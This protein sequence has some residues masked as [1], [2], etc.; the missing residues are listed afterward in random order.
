MS[1]WNKNHKIGPITDNGVKKA[2]NEPKDVETINIERE[3]VYCDVEEDNESKIIYEP[4]KFEKFLN[5]LLC[6]GDLAKR[7]LDVKPVTLAGLFKFGNTTDILILLLGI[8]FATLSGIAQPVLTLLA[9]RVTNAMIVY[10]PTSTEFFESAIENVYLFGG[11]GIVVLIINFLQYLCFQVCCI[12]IVSKIRHKYILSILRQNTGW[13]DKNH[14]GTLTTKLNDNINRIRDGIGDKLG[15]LL[16]GIVMFTSGLVISYIYEWRLALFM[17]GTAP[18]CCICMSLMSRTISKYTSKELG[19]IGKAGSIAEECLMGVRTVQSLNG[20]EEMTEKYTNE[21]SHGRKYAILKGVSGGFFG[22]LFFLL[23]FSYLGGGFYYGAYLMEIKTIET[24]GDVFTVVFSMLL[25]AYFLGLISPHLM[26]LLNA[27]VAAATIYEI[28]EREPKIDAYS[29]EGKKPIHINGRVT[30]NNVHFR[31]PLRKNVKVLNGLNLVVE[32]GTSVAL[33]GHSGC[34]K[35]TSVGLLTRLYECEQ[36]SVE[37]DGIDVKDLNIDWLR[38]NVG[39]VQQEPI[40]FNDTIHNNLLVG[41]LQATRQKMI[42][43]CKMA[44]AHDFIIKMPKGYDTL[45]GDGGVQLSGGQ[46]QRVAI[47]RTLIRDP[48]I[49]LLDEATSALDAESESIVQSALNNAAAGRTTIMIAHRLSTI[50]EA[51]KIVYFENGVVVESGTHEELVELGGR[52]YNLVQ[53]QQFKSSESDDEVFEDDENITPTVRSRTV[54]RQLSI[55]SYESF[56]IESLVNTLSPYHNIMDQR[57]QEDEDFAAEVTRVMDEDGAITAGYMDI[58]KNAEGNYWYLC[59]GFITALFRGCELPLLSVIMGVVFD[60]F[61]KTGDERS[62]IILLCFIFYIVVGLIT[63]L[64]Q[65]ASTILFTIVA[66]NLGLRFRVKSFRNLLHQ[67]ASFFDNPAHSPGKLITRLASDAPNVKAVVDSRMLQVIYSITAIIVNIIVGFFLCWQIALLENL[68]QIKK[69]E[70]GKI[71][72]EIIENVKTIQLLTATKT[73]YK[74]YEQASDSQKKIDIRKAIIEAVNNAVSQSFMYF[75][76]CMAYGLGTPLIHNQFV[77]AASAFSAINTMLLSSVAVMHSSHNFPEFVK[78]KTAAGMLFKMI[79]RQSKTGDLMQG[80]TPEIRGN[81]LFENVKFSYPQRPLQPVMTNLHFSAQRGQT[82]AIVGP[83][84]SG[85]STCI[86]MLERFYDT[87]AG[88]I[89]IDGND[90]R[91]LSLHHIRTQMALVGQE[92]RLF[93]G[94]IKENICLGLKDVPLERINEALKLSN[95]S[96]FM[97]SLPAGIDTEVGEKG[98]QL[99]GGQKQR[100]AIARALVR[101]PKILLL[102]EAT[103]ALDSQSEK[104]VQ[105]ALDRARTGR[106][107]ITIA[108]R[109]SSIQN[110]DLIVYI[111]HGIVQEAGNHQQLMQ[112][113]G[114]YYN[115]IKKQDLAT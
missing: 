18:I 11:V 90:I 72:I 26:V 105:E 34:G 25:G 27:R 2:E 28:I 48:K 6:R 44:N 55:R 98:S 40:L 65:F 89:R 23:L 4:S 39:I 83:S 78:A 103:S 35:S 31:Y 59:F 93:A 14:S 46:K 68:R 76:M 73:F 84:G 107:C 85:K 92:P 81:I 21:L 53:A 87:N 115:L 113:K 33:V 1:R 94:T 45:I 79:Y 5:Y 42:E 52:Y 74:K 86:S 15:V 30:F 61:S 7:E 60:G 19:D 51:D 22:G 47:A 70:A 66:E 62:Q 67:D 71:S 20:Q 10:S 64:G 16:R 57:G 80:E 106:T 77:D 99:S 12:R 54:S 108:H 41:N 24:P 114:K 8:L 50:R 82:V 17:T 75:M 88:C 37:I 112:R 43:V 56:D 38:Q 95:A 69:D 36:G 101:N 104:A 109:L 32:P 29:N 96:R 9:G 49:L 63:F 111:E 13:F 102:D 91:N 97:S 100:I 58:L 3:E 110:A